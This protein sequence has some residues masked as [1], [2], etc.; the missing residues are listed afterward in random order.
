MSNIT[1]ELW[2]LMRSRSA[3][4]A[5][6]LLVLCSAASVALGLASVAR[7]RA[8]I[9]RMLAGQTAEERALSAFVA[10][11]GS[12]AYYGFQ[13]TWDSPSDL[14]FAA[15]GSRDIAPAM[16]R[17]RALALE[18]QIYENEAANPE[19]ALPGRFDLAF[20]AVYL[21]PLVL[22]AL[23]HDLWSGEREAGRYH[24]LAALPQARKRLWTAR[25]LVRVGGVL[26]ALLLPFFAG[27]IIA[28][29]APLRA[30]GF[31]GL[32]V[33]VVLL[34]T[35]IVL[36]VAR[37]G[38]RSAVHAAS[39]AAIWFALTLVAPAGAN[40]AINAAV[41]VPDGAALAR[42][43]REHVHA[44][45]DR[46]RDQTMRDFLKLYPRYASGAAIPPTF[47]WKWYFAFQHLGDRHVAQQSQ[48]YRE[49]IERRADLARLAGWLLPPAGLA[50]A[51]TQLAR[52][53]VAAQLDYQMRIR[54]YHQRLREFYYDY[55]FS[56]K[57]FGP[58]ELQ[59]VPRFDPAI[60]G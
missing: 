47:H 1:R 39:L 11:A 22:I 13:P 29:T 7:D 54:A 57:P 52:T 19:L 31:A 38:G 48:A 32:I 10:D 56:E 35:A 3:L 17:V 37:R 14:A 2:L 42:E 43:N 12:G 16:L 59:R 58:E 45:W 50:Q 26:A 28:G 4:L 41:A 9:D 27:A 20:V 49:G 60:G 23:L 18:A 51:M 33:L 6:A 8:A 21:A 5:L 55:L 40:L 25:V 53:D 30:L 34:W 15:L 44:G 46:P 24:A 36:L